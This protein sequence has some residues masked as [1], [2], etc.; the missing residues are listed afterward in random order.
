MA[1]KCSYKLFGCPLAFYELSEINL[2][3]KYLLNA[4]NSSCYIVGVL[5][6]LTQRMFFENSLYAHSVLRSWAEMLQK[7]RWEFF[8]LS[9]PWVYDYEIICIPSN[10]GL[11]LPLPRPFPPLLMRKE[12]SELEQCIC[13]SISKGLLHNMS[14]LPPGPTAGKHAQSEMNH[15]LP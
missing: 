4:Y 11:F 10:S 6:W 15:P 2:F 1:T 14:P 9:E 13:K 8:F 7:P 3:R 5:W 12:I